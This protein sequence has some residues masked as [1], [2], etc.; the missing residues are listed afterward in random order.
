MKT[1][2]KI[3]GYILR[4]GAAA[5]F[6]LFV[7]IALSSAINLP[8]RSPKFPAPQNNTALSVNAQLPTRGL[9]VQFERR[10][11]P[12]GYYN[13]DL[14]HN[15]NNYDP[16]V[17]HTVSEEV[18]LQLDAMQAMGV[19]TITF[20]LRTA[21]QDDN[22]T[23]PTCHTNPVLGFQW[24]QPTA[25]ELA[26]LPL[27]F[28]LAESKGMKVILSTTNTH[29]EEQPPTNS[30]TWLGAI[31]NVV[32]NHPALD[33][34]LFNGDAKYITDC[35]GVPVDCG[36]QAEPP[37]W[38]GLTEI[39]ATYVKW[40]ISYAMSLGVPATKLSAESIVGDYFTVS[41]PPSCLV[42]DGHLWP[43]IVVMKQILDNLGV[44][45]AQRLYALSFY[46]HT[47]CSTARGLPCVDASP[48]VWAEQT[49][50]NEVFS[51]IGWAS[52]ARV[53][54]PEMG[55][56]PPV[57]STWTTTQA[58]ESL[59]RLMAEYGIDG[60]S[61]WRWTSFD[62]S[63]DQDPTLAQPIK[64]RGVDFTYTPAKTVLECYYTGACP[65]PTPIP[66]HPAFFT[67]ETALDNGVYYLQFPNGTPFGY[68]AY[69]T[70]LRFIYH[71]DMGYE[72][73]F[74]A[75]D[76]Q[77]GIYF[78]DFTSNHFFYTSPSS[79]PYLYDFSLNAWLYYLPDFNNPG[80]YSHN[81]RWFY[82]FATG[83]W[84]TL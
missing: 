80:H 43:P 78:Y 44:P 76:G 63:E 57:Q 73:W 49:L 61:F 47:K 16:I 42:T 19:N 60:G 13:G 45:N 23:F 72:Y 48:P 39:P 54:A 67:G 46:E 38:L 3:S 35:N 81:P 1:K 21:D 33:S 82:N 14:I 37:L 74:D 24:P 84:I 4:S 2:S 5:L 12:N 41:E 9:F 69:L 6:F 30:E 75:N 31:L 11:W 32:G 68:Y 15:W 29:M 70:D 51:T 50:Q 65:L 64:L 27:F 58:I 59:I 36:G 26:N 22:H 62:N 53:V 56:L 28:D 40:A 66:M 52:G 79:F 17:G 7:V 77:G 10:G 18:A 25:T 34:V 8:N 20:E 71:F 55:D 83:Q